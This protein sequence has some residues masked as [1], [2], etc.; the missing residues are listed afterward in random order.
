MLGTGAVQAALSVQANGTVYDDV[1]DISWDRDANAVGTLCKTNDPIW[2][3]FTP[4]SGRT[5]AVICASDGDLYW[6]EA[7][8]WIAHLNDRSYKGITDWRLWT[9]TQPDSSCSAQETS[10]S[11]P[12][13]YNYGCTGS[14]LG[15]MFYSAPPA[16]LGN[17]RA[18]D[19]PTCAPSC[20]QNTG[21][22]VNILQDRYWSGTSFAFNASQ[23]WDFNTGTGSQQAP[24]KTPITAFAWA[25]R[26]GQYQ[27]VPTK[28]D[29]TTSVSC[30]TPIRL[31]STSNCEATV[32]RNSGG[33]TPSGTLFWGRTDTGGS[34]GTQSC[35]QDT[36]SG[37]LTCTI[38]YTPG[39]V[40][41]HDVLAVFGG[42]ENFNSSS[43]ET[44]VGVNQAPKPIPAVGPLGLLLSGLGLGLLGIWRVRRKG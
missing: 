43:G 34:F 15:H 2:T 5:L 39:E 37:T 11:P 17:S 29:T 32:T 6:S 38:G 8:E 28:A 33:Y 1:Q 22:F 44:V 12:Q 10:Y 31:G 13:G 9:T 35:N 24:N 20:F 27:P 3:S 7:V 21:P 42:D 23:A 4:T 40:G 18:D 14:E 26:P 19:N 41:S 30:Q 36:G 25:V 16:G